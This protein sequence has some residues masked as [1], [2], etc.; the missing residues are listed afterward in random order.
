MAHGVLFLGLAYLDL[1]GI[2]LTHP[3]RPRM[4]RGQAGEPVA[5]VSIVV[6]APA[7]AQ[8]PID[9]PVDRPKE[10]QAEPTQADSPETPVGPAPTIAELPPLPELPEAPASPG[11]PA[12]SDVG[13]LLADKPTPPA[14]SPSDAAPAATEDV[15]VTRGAEPAEDIHPRY[16][17]SCIRRG[18]Q[19][20]VLLRVEVLA[21]GRAGRI[22]VVQSTTHRK[23]DQAAIDAARNARFTP[24]QRNGRPVDAW[25]T[26][27]FVF[28]L[29]D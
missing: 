6:E 21:H 19:G 5:T 3:P 14:P 4:S 28:R 25:V 2:S 27:P 15:G 18:Q 29:T 11:P 24:A 22:E 10:T 16:P 23:L 9:R 13:P 12:P 7:V 8:A 17:P 26:I 1:A 20:Q